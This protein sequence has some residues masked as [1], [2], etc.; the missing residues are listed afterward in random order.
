MTNLCKFHL[1]EG[2]FNEN[3]TFA[4]SRG[5]MDAFSSVENPF[6]RTIKCKNFFNNKFCKYGNACLYKH[7]LQGC[8]KIRRHF[9]IPKLSTAS[10]IYTDAQVSDYEEDDETCLSGASRLPIFASI[11]ANKEFDEIDLKL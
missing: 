5:E 2:C 11:H 1:N 9:Y 4:H 7:E 6:W 10:Y 3:C 8:K